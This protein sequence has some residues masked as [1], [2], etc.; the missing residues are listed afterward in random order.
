MYYTGVG[1]RKAPSD[2]LDLMYRFAQ[3]QR[4]RKLRSG[5][6]YGPDTAFEQGALHSDIY[7]PWRKPNCK[8]NYIVN[9]TEKQNAFADGI[10][11]E[12]FPYRIYRQTTRALFR[13]NV[14]QV[15]GLCHSVNDAIPSEFMVCYTEDGATCEG[16]Y[17]VGVTGGTGI[18]IC[19]ADMFHVP[20]YN[21]GRFDHRQYISDWVYFKEASI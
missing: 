3:L 1:S 7:L 6:A 15:I 12:V 20:V 16:E 5:N 10:L 18:A 2:V 19:I 17:V 9:Y 11:E 8:D 14:W 21:L 4:K 13:R